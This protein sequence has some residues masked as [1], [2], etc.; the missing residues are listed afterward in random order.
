[1]TTP[2]A[3]SSIDGQTGKII[4]PLKYEIGSLKSQL[5]KKGRP[6]RQSGCHAKSNNG[7]SYL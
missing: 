1:M 7:W 4:D 5:K 3:E 6:D 2:N